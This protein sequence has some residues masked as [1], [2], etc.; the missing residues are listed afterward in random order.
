MIRKRSRK[1][2][3]AASDC[4]T[5]PDSIGRVPRGG[6]GQSFKQTPAQTSDRRDFEKDRTAATAG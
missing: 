5:R 3:A 2:F 6:R 4:K 1:K